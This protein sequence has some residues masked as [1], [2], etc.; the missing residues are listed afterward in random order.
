MVRRAAT[1]CVFMPQA[2]PSQ[3]SES[4]KIKLPPQKHTAKTAETA[5]TPASRGSKKCRPP[6]KRTDNTDNTDRADRAP[7]SS[8]RP[9]RTQT[10]HDAGNGSRHRSAPGGASEALLQHDWPHAAALLSS[11]PPHAAEPPP[12]GNFLFKKLASIAGGALGSGGL[13]SACLLS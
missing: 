13:V 12:A 1:A 10:Q 8:G 4:R 6:L 2:Q 7:S 11:I 9:D 3:R 5:K